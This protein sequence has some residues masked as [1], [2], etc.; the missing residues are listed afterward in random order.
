[1]QRSQRI[2]TIKVRTQQVNITTMQRLTPATFLN[3]FPG[4]IVEHFYVKFGNPS[5][6]GY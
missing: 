6:I 3:E 2:S 1:M 4:L 5:C